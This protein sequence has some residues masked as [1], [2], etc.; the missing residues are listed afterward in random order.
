MLHGNKKKIIKIF[1]YLTVVL[2]VPWTGRRSNQSILK[3][4][5]SWIFIRRT[6][7]EAPIKKKCYMV[8]S[9]SGWVKT[10]PEY[11][12]YSIIMLRS[13]IHHIEN[14]ESIDVLK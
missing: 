6:D 7:T 8:N 10:L 4:N 9:A 13:E 2:R 12:M 1:T 5:Q 11:L 14:S 3:G